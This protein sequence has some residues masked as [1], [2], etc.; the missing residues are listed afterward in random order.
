M[1]SY[2]PAINNH[3]T[4]AFFTSPSSFASAETRIP[5]SNRPDRTSSKLLNLGC[6]CGLEMSREADHK[7]VFS[8]HHISPVHVA[9]QMNFEPRPSYPTENPDRTMPATR[10]CCARRGFRKR[11]GS[12]HQVVCGQP[13]PLS[14]HGLQK[15]LVPR[16]DLINQAMSIH[17]SIRDPSTH[18]SIHLFSQSGVNPSL[19][20]ASSIKHHPSN[21]IEPRIHPLITAFLLAAAA[22]S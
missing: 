11:E 10:A 8:F 6:L 5:G 12:S 22:T 1:I 16:Q 13:Q 21:I 9:D 19:D 4:P 17:R 7:P 2:H 14:E 18:S 15:H 3:Q 20:P